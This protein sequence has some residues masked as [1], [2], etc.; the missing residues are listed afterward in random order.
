MLAFVAHKPM[1]VP[2]QFRKI[3]YEDFA[4]HRD[5]LD[6]IFWT[7]A[8]EGLGNPLNDRLDEVK[9]PTLIIWGRHDQLIDVSC[10]DILENGIP[11][12]QSVVFEDVGHVPMIEKPKATGKHHVEFLAKH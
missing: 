11:N 12:A 10:V 6:K 3:F 7:I 8:E 2:G 1:R 4:A 5:L 9:T